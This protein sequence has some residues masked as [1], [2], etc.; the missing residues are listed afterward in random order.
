MF[1]YIFAVLVS[2]YIYRITTRKMVTTAFPHAWKPG[3]PPAGVVLQRQGLPLFDAVTATAHS[4]QDSMIAGKLKSTD[5][6]EEYVRRI[7]EYNEY[8]RAV[9]EYA[10]GAMERAREMDAKRAAGEFLGPLHG[11]PVLLKDTFA[12]EPSLKMSTTAGA[13]ALISSKPVAN[14]EVVDK[15]LAVGA[16]ILGK[17]T[18]SEL[19]FRKGSGIPCGWSAIAGQGQSPYVRG[20][21]DLNDS[22]GGHSVPGGSSSGVSIAISAGFAAVGVGSDTEA[23]ITA[24]AIRASLYSIRPTT[25]I[26]S[27]SGTIPV[28]KSF[29]IGGPM[30]KDV[31]DV[32]DMLTVLV[33]PKKTTVTDGGYASVLNK[34]KETLKIGTL[35]P[36]VWSYPEFLVKP[37]PEATEQMSKITLEAYSQIKSLV[38]TCHENVDL[39][40]VSEFIF[41]GGH[42]IYTILD[43]ELPEVINKYLSNLAISPV[44]SLQELVDWNKEHSTEALPSEYPNQDQLIQALNTNLSPEEIEENRQHYLKVGSNLDATFQ[45]YGINII[46]GPGDCFLTQYASAKGY[47]I[48]ALPL[49]YLDFNGRPVGLQAITSAHREDLLLAFMG[50]YE[51]SIARRQPPTAFLEASAPSDKSAQL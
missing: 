14:A 34:S 18:V 40:P 26:V 19:S 8:L 21:F 35:D 47:P 33:D 37:I 5:L 43:V 6:V 27:T 28:S 7:E 11:I 49:T 12:T 4:L 2:F 42:S 41:K 32:A 38:G 13:V 50:A 39:A 48:A 36:N 25:G 44:R 22:I 30:A 46:V 16:V 20:G 10:P 31:R 3:N 9:S 24:P 1:S 15:L 51:A 23:S 17:T 45:K 29:D